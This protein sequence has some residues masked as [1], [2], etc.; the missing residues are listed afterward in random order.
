M[1]RARFYLLFLVPYTLFCSMGAVLAGLIDRTGRW[2]HAWARLW[3]L[4]CAVAARVRIDV[5][6]LDR[7]PTEGPVIYMG[8]HQG[9]FDIHALCLAI[10]RQFS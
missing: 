5:E 9:N 8:N 1:W 6:G 7:V 3:S 10:P 2:S 4:G